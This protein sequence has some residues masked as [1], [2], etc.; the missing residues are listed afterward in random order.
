MRNTTLTTNISNTMDIEQIV[1]KYIKQKNTHTIIFQNHTCTKKCHIYHVKKIK[2]RLGTLYPDTYF[3]KKSGNIHECGVKC[4]KRVSN[5]YGVEYC[6]L[7]GKEFLPKMS[8][9][10]FQNNIIKTNKYDKN[11][12]SRINSHDNDDIE[13]ACAKCIYF[14]LFSKKRQAVEKKKYADT[15]INANKLIGKYKR[16]CEKKKITKQFVHILILYFNSLQKKAFYTIS[17]LNLTLYQM[18][19]K[20]IYYT[21]L[22]IK[23]WNFFK[24]MDNELDFGTFVIAILYIF[25]RGLF[26]ENIV[27][28]PKDYFLE[29]ALPEANTLS[30]YGII[31]PSF[32]FTKNTLL[33]HMCRLLKENNLFVK[34]FIS[35]FE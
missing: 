7:T 20:L 19:Q 13:T 2:A 22:I 21:D 25:K 1:K 33:N 10:I 17:N 16:Q 5:K 3:C 6:F 4:N 32:T 14:I 35:I 29:K 9:I 18:K 24:E 23:L 15:C 12:K 31:K 30:D 11:T 26:H 28:I 34:N 8:G 27:I